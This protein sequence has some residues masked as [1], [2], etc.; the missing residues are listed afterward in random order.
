LRAYGPN[1]L[2]VPRAAGAQPAAVSARDARAAAPAIPDAGAATPEAGA[3][4]LDEP[5]LDAVPGALGSRVT[6]VP[7]LIAGGTAAGHAATIVGADFERLRR[8]YPGWRIEPAAQAPPAGPACVLG[9]ALARRAGKRPGESI[10]IGAGN[11]PATLLVAGVVSTGEAEDEQV[12]VPLPF[13]QDLLGR[14]G[15]VSFAALS[16]DGGAPAVERAGAALE[17]ALPQAQARPLRAIA[18]AQGA[19]LERLDRMMLLLTLV[20]LVLSGLC[21]VTTLMSMVAERE[22]EIGLARAIGAGDGEIFRMFLGEVGLLGVLGAFAGLLIG[23]GV[24][25]LI[26]RGLFG[27]AIEPRLSVAPIVL[28]LSMVICL[29]AVYVPLRRALAIQPAAALRGD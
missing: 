2:I 19:I 11:R 24:T 5:A 12:F 3:A 29:I 8:L 13:L 22:S 21:L 9:A 10:D 6:V 4:T 16:I 14:P 26:G 17:Q 15:R 23:A 7:I 28:G 20:I 1:L 18:M 27:A 25:R